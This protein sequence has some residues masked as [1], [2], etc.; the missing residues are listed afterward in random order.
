MTRGG[1]I[2]G[3]GK[4]GVKGRRSGVRGRTWKEGDGEGGG[5]GNREGDGDGE[6][7]GEG[8]REEEG[9]EEGGRER[10]GNECRV[11]CGATM[12]NGSVVHRRGGI[13]GGRAGEMGCRKSRTVKRMEA[14]W[15]LVVVCCCL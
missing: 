9:G 7:G 8:M 11:G 4:R 10:F 1:G 6:G 5:E 12:R 14:A 3:G 15:I 2:R 13:G